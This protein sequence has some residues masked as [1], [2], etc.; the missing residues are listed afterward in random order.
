MKK[1]T[2]FRNLK[3]DGHVDIDNVKNQLTS[4]QRNAKAIEGQLNPNTEYPSW[5]IN[6]LVKAADY[7]DTAADFLQ[8][9]KDQG[10]IDEA[11]VARDID[12]VRGILKDL[13]PYFYKGLQKG[14]EKIMAQLN[15]IAKYVNQGITKSGQAKNKTFL[16]K[17]KRKL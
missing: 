8:T 6:K 1:F 3:E 17:L 5:W 9:K 13:E 16:Y 2:E 15:S 10:E 11:L 4:L 7:V 12:I 14:D